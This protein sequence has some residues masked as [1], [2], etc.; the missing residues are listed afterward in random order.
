M[1]CAGLLIK[2]ISNRMISDLN[3]HLKR[4]ELTSTQLEIL[5]YLHER[6]G[7]PASQ[8]EIGEYLCVRHTSVIDVLRKLEEKELV[9]KSVNREN[10]RFRDIA[11]TAKA[12]EIIQHLDDKRGETDL[13]IAEALHMKDPDE[14]IGCLKE[15][16]QQIC[17]I[18][19]D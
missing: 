11:I 18:E 13:L 15:A 9:T 19:N 3:R 4:Y 7:Q 17:S 14:L 1:E 8:K 5:T 16:Y 2:Q 12:E 6:G 10:A